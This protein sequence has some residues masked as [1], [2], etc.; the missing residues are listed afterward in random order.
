VAQHVGRILI[1]AIGTC[2]QQFV[3]P[4]AAGEQP[5]AERASSASREQIPDAVAH[6]PGVLDVHAEPACCREEQVRVGLRVNHIVSSDDRNCRTDAQQLQRRAGDVQS[7][8]RGDSE[9]NGGAGQRCQQLGRPWE[10]TDVGCLLRVALRVQLLEP[11]G[12]LRGNCP[13]DLPQKR[14]GEEP[15]AHPDASVDSPDGAL[16][17]ELIQ[18]RTPGENVLVDAV[19]ERPIEIEEKRGPASWF[20][21][22]HTGILRPP[23]RETHVVRKGPHRL[24]VRDVQRPGT[25]VLEALSPAARARIVDAGLDLEV[26]RGGIVYRQRAKPRCALVLEGLFRVYLVAPDGREV[27]VRYVRPGALLG[28]AAL[29]A[30][31]SPVGVQALTEARLR[32]IDL[33]SL[34]EEAQRDAHVAWAIAQELAAR[35]NETLDYLAVS[36]FSSVRERIARHL[37]ATASP[38]RDGRM[39]ANLTQQELASAT[40]T[41]R[42]VASRALRQLHAAGMLRTRPGGVILLDVAALEAVAT[43]SDDR[44]V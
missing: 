35:L 6:H 22:S 7:S 34:A 5:D 20:R 18:C 19:H 30:G 27:T 31:P 3:V 28:I 4:V 11:F 12:F 2:L 32:F 24:N 23:G 37:L 9:R 36:A 29:V 14:V 21:N 25:P 44:Q 17:S 1:D 41:A 8:A 16:D 10:L 40:G 33:R 43:G 15:A 38:G 42:E 26:P 39:V 13:S